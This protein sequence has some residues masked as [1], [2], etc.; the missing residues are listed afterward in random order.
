VILTYKIRHNK[1]FVEELK[2]AKQVAE[3][4]IEHKILSSAKVKQFG[5]LY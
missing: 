4:G 5:Y 2:K 3:F 1:G